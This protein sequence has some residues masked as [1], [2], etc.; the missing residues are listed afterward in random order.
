MLESITT[1]HF[2]TYRSLK[3]NMMPFIVGDQDSLPED[4]RPYVD[5]IDAC[6]IEHRKGKTAYLTVHESF[7]EE[8][9]TQRRPGIHT[10]ATNKL[11]WGGDHWGGRTRSEGIYLAS[12]DGACQAWG[13]MVRSEDVDALGALLERPVAPAQTLQ[14][15]HLY[16]ITDRTPHEAL[17]AT[18]SGE[19]QFFRLVVG[20]IDAWFSQ[21]NTPNPLGV[22][23][24]A[25]I[26]EYNKF[27]HV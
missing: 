22:P 5:I 11:G 12:T 7:V 25:P 17:P 21:H 1:V 20:D 24:N 23:P 18:R 16:W 13:L 14:A 9:K 4:L 3:V 19:R 27:L 15:N 10:D 2:P 26:V 6:S 8:G